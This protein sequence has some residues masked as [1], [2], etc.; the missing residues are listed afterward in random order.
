MV[1]ATENYLA[2]AQTDDDDWLISAQEPLAGLQRDCGGTLPGMIA[3]PELLSLVVKCRTYGFSLARSISAITQEHTVNAWVEVSPSTTHGCTIGIVNWSTKPLQ[4]GDD[5]TDLPRKHEIEKNLSDFKACL[6]ADQCV[7]TAI[8]D[9]DDTLELADK[10]TAGTGQPWTNFV[11]LSDGSRQQPV[12]WR[13]LDGASCTIPGS[14]RRWNATLIPHISSGEKRHGFELYLTSDEPYSIP[15][16]KAK[17]STLAEIKPFLSRDLG[18]VLRQPIAR[19]IANAET[20]RTKLAGP[21]AEEYSSYAADIS[22]AGQH[23]LSL[24]EDLTDLEVVESGGFTTAHDIIDLGDCARRTSGILGVKATDK[25]IALIA[26]SSS[27]RLMARGEFRRVLQI[28]INI[29]GNAITYAPQGSTVSITI[30]DCGDFA[31]ISVT[32]Q[33][34]GLSSEQSDAVFNKFERLGRSGDSGTGLG[35]YISRCLARAMGGEL[36]VESRIGQGAKFTLTLPTCNNPSDIKDP[37]FHH[38]KPSLFK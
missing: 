38:G 24:V 19:I 32:D 6:D 28:L 11:E 22:T 10:M 21:L 18:P 20:I 36:V 12:H 33:G 1:S 13:L 2:R 3:I 26:P 25:N 17:N 7:M 23:L 27:Q 14:K 16:L 31:A 34:P 8:A 30:E 29:V 35:L 15:N 9:A 5:I 4:A 37:A